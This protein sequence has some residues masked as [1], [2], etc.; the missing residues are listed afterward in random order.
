M[1]HSVYVIVPLAEVTQAMIN[2]SVTGRLEKVR[3]CPQG[4][5]CLFEVP[6]EDAR[7]FL[8][9]QWYSLSEIQEILATESWDG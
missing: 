6:R 3:K 7:W 2:V 1:S 5:N 4:T 9:Y 8:D